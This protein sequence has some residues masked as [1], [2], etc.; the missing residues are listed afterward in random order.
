VD[1]IFQILGEADVPRI[2]HHKLLLWDMFPEKG[3]VFLVY[4]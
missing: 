1:D 4:G 2:H 3:I